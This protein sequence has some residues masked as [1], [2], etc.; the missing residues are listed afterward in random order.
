MYI[1]APKAAAPAKGT[2]RVQLPVCDV[3][4]MH[5]MYNYYL[6]AEG[7]YT[8]GWGSSGFSGTLG[9]VKNLATL[10]T[11]PGAEV[12]R[13][14][15]AKQVQQMQKQVSARA[16]ARARAAGADPIRVRL[17]INGQ[18]F[19]LEKILALPEDKLHFQVV[20]RDWK[21]AK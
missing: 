19:K 3:P 13:K 7:K 8:V 17:P 10:S 14:N 11:G 16:D 4:M 2:M 6:P 1:E 5:V 9:I 18:L 15:V 12:I 21:P 20:Y